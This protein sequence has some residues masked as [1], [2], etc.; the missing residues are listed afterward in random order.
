M[1]KDSERHSIYVFSLPD[2]K[3]VFYGYD[4]FED[5]RR[6]DWHIWKP[7]DKGVPAKVGYFCCVDQCWVCKKLFQVGDK[8]FVSCA[9]LNNEYYHVCESCV[10]DELAK[11]ISELQKRQQELGV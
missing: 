5:T 3:A 4:P 1:E 2:A 8:V 11:A 9:P 6:R 10:R 7:G